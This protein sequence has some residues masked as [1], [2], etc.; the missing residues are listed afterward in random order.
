MCGGGGGGGDG[1]AAAAAAA[2]ADRRAKIKEGTAKIDQIFGGYSRGTGAVS[3]APAAGATYYLADGTPV[4][5]SEVQ[6]NAQPIYGGAGGRWLSEQGNTW[7]PIPDNE[8]PITG[9][10]PGT[11]RVLMANGQEM[12]Y[13]G[14]G[15]YSGMEKV[16]GFD[17]GFYSG[18]ENKYLEYANPQLESQYADARRA[19]EYNLED[20]GLTSSTAAAERWRKMDEQYN[21]YRTDVTSAAKAYSQRARGDIENARTNLINQLSLTEDPAA[22]AAG[23]VRASAQYSQPPAFDPLG[24]FVFDVSQGLKQESANRGYEPLF[25]TRLFNNSGKSSISYVN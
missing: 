11:R 13:T 2:E 7:I 4:T 10:T 16:A 18:L 15:L 20:R 12:D 23:A 24:Q 9:Y 22:A 25:G 21:K 8:R 5:Y 17:D 3:G 14:Q 1:G 19:L 6:G